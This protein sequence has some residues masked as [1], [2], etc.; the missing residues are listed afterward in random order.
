MNKTPSKD[1][2]H[3]CVERYKQFL[4]ERKK[5]SDLLMAKLLPPKRVVVIKFK[6]LLPSETESQ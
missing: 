3:E 2:L 6:K 1:A 4:S 5:S